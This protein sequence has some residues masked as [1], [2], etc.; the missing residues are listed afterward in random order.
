M[1]VQERPPR[2]I[3]TPYTPTTS[4][5]PAKPLPCCVRCSGEEIQVIPHGPYQEYWCLKCLHRV[6]GYDYRQMTLLVNQRRY[7]INPEAY[8][9][10]LENLAEAKR[11]PFAAPAPR[12][13]AQELPVLASLPEQEPKPPEEPIPAA[14]TPALKRARGVPA[15]ILKALGQHGTMQRSRIKAILGVAAGELDAAQEL[16]TRKGQLVTTAGPYNCTIYSLPGA[17]VKGNY[18]WYRKDRTQHQRREFVESKPLTWRLLRLLKQKG[19]LTRWKVRWNLKTTAKALDEAGEILI[20]RG[21]LIVVTV[22]GVS[23]PSRL[24]S[25]A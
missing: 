3:L 18:L 17:D 20:R 2:P 19:P 9:E 7:R 5:T 12:P 16:L 24:Y 8:Q 10:H 15:R 22:K 6:W 13:E 1:V 4:T 11:Q 14:I 23:N 25:L 21:K